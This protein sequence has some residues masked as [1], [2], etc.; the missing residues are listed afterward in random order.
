MGLVFCIVSLSKSNQPLGTKGRGLERKI[1]RG[2]KN[3]DLYWGTKIF[4]FERLQSSSGV[5]KI[6][7]ELKRENYG[8]FS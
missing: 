3:F 7:I 1:F 2:R 6:E 4:Q 8:E 5:A